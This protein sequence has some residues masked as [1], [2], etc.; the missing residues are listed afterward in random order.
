MPSPAPHTLA[1]PRAHRVSF[2]CALG[3]GTVAQAPAH[4]EAEQRQQEAMLA[5][6][7]QPAPEAPAPSADAAGPSRME[8]VADDGAAADLPE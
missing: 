8:G 5:V 7:A 1:P 2:V 6:L 3:S 4:L